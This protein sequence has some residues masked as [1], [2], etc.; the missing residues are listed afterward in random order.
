MCSRTAKNANI[1]SRQ[2]PIAQHTAL[3]IDRERGRRR[4]TN[5]RRRE[6][7]AEQIGCDERQQRER[8][9]RDADADIRI[10]RQDQ[11]K[12]RRRRK[13]RLPR[14]RGIEAAHLARVLQV[15]DGIAADVR[16]GIAAAT[17]SRAST[18]TRRPPPARCI[19]ASHRGSLVGSV[20]FEERIQPQERGVKENAREKRGYNEPG[21]LHMPRGHG[22]SYDRIGD[23]VIGDCGDVE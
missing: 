22:A 12:P 9:R 18:P 11:S 14:V 19:D 3:L 16:L 8:D 20:G 23:S 5:R 2:P 1:S 15:V 4:K 10:A 13:S 17:A 21:D 6:L 7:P